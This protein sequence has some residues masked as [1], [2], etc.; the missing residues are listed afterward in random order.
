MGARLGY[1][2]LPRT[3]YRINTNTLPSN[4]S[5]AFKPNNPLSGASVGALTAASEKR[6]QSARLQHRRDVQRRIVLP[7]VIG[8]IVAIIF[9]LALA[10][11]FSGRQIGIIASFS[12]VILIVPM[13]LLCMIPYALLIVGVAGMGRVHQIT[14]KALIRGQRMSRSIHVGAVR[15][16]KASTRPFIAAQKRLAW[17]DR[18]GRFGR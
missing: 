8:A 6:S 11:L 5:N 2:Y 12:A 9:L 10:I 7:V 16:S 4:G 3:S 18:F 17:L 13:V 14:E 15:V 1:V